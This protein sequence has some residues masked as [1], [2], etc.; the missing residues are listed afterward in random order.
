MDGVRWRAR[1]GTSWSTP[2][3]E[4]SQL[5]CLSGRPSPGGRLAWLPGNWLEPKEWVLQACS[6]S[7]VLPLAC[8]PTSLAALPRGAELKALLLFPWGG[9]WQGPGQAQLSAGGWWG[10]SREPGS[11]P[12]CLTDEECQERGVE[13]VP[14]CL[15][16]KRRRREDQ[17]DGDGPPRPREAFWEP[18]SSDDG[19]A[20]SDSDDSMTDL[21][22]RKLQCSGSGS[23]LSP[24]IPS[25]SRS[26]LLHVR[27][28][29]WAWLT[30]RHKWCT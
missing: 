14:A 15:L 23:R 17:Q 16:H 19:V 12:V 29:S 20:P 9:G 5:L 26:L 21:Y 18:P 13:F 4:G 1:A 2:S 11:I 10:D 24:R 6:V 7:T 22:P 25:A 8:T 27:L 28:W 3:R 30:P